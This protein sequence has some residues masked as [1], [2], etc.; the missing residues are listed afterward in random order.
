MLATVA[1]LQLLV[2]AQVAVPPNPTPPDGAQPAAEAPAPPPAPQPLPT[3]RPRQQS[4]LSGE[5]LRGGSAALA[6]AGWSD[7]GA[8]YAIG[9]TQLDDAGPFLSY[10]WAKSESRFGVFYR[11][12]IS[13]VGAFDLAGRLS[14]AWYANL[15]STYVYGD[16]HSDH[17]FEV[18]PG[19]SLSTHGAG[20]ILS[21][22]AA[23]PMIITTKYKNGFLFTPWLAAAFEA[24]LYPSVTVG[25]TVGIGY[26]AGAGNA[27]LREGRGELKFLVLAGYQLL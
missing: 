9:F 22:L 19:V 20:G 26:R 6:W 3:G 11:R 17:G 27:P 18:V 25:A 2:A 5:S 24:P 10:D 14:A 7:L 15:G 23:A 13:K 16:N 1:A 4:L 21:G 12:A 8:I